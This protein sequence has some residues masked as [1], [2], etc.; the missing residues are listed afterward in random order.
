MSKNNAYNNYK[1]LLS[2]KIK[3]L[4]LQGCWTSKLLSPSTQY[5]FKK[6]EETDHKTNQMYQM[7][8]YSASF[9]TSMLQ[10]TKKI[11]T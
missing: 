4:K 1:V 10:Y 5:C 2:E 7:N 9:S 8:K 6:V 11:S 3:F